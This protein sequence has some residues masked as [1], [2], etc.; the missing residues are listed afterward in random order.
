[1]KVATHSKLVCCALAGN[2]YYSL[3]YLLD[4]SLNIPQYQTSR[5]LSQNH[6]GPR[7]FFKSDDVDEKIVLD[8]LTADIVKRSNRLN[9]NC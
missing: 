6:N 2:T 9:R 7:L 4:M 1:M 5:P 3:L 8:G